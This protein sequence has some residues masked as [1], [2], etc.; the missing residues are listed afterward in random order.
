MS[1]DMEFWMERPPEKSHGGATGFKP[2]PGVIVHQIPP[3]KSIGSMMLAGELD[4]ALHYLVDHNL[5][6][7]SRA[8]LEN[9]PDF[10]FLFPDPVAE[11]IRYYKKTGLLPINHQAVVRRD[12]ADKEPWVVINLLK[13]FS[14]A[15]DIANAQRAAHVEYH[16]ATGPAVRRCQDASGRS[17]A[18]RPTARWSRPSRRC[19]TSRG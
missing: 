4:A 18:S 16:L 9:H 7:R 15:N 11:G 5:V 1:Q 10:R 13:A 19:R 2:P 8:D 14:R 3:D 12:V 6:D 17:T